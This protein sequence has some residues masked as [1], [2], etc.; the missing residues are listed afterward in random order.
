[1]VLR[2][3]GYKRFIHQAIYVIQGIEN[4]AKCTNADHTGRKP[5]HQKADH[6]Q[7]T[8]QCDH[9]RDQIQHKLFS[10]GRNV[11]PVILL[12]RFPVLFIKIR[13]QAVYPD[14]F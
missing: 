11:K 4:S 14:L 9:L 5:L 10:V 8:C 3:S 6:C 1:M 7:K 13:E 2:N 12:P